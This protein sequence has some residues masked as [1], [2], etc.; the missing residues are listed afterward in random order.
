MVVCGGQSGTGTGLLSEY[1]GFPCQSSFL[2]F[3]HHHN[4]PGLRPIGGRSAEWTQMDPP[5]TI[6]IILWLTVYRTWFF[7]LAT[8]PLRLTTSNFIFQL[9]TCGYSPYVTS[10]LMMSFTIGAGPR[11]RSKVRLPRDSWPHFIA[12][13]SRLSQPGGPD[14]L[15]YRVAQLYP[16]ALGSLFV[17]S[18]NSHSHDERIRPHLHTRDDREL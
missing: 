15:I 11:Q 14:N 5:P 16:K 3:L 18:Y 9:N 4:H 12:S 1:Y 7:V 8:S 2:R 10:S 17:A 13:N 6:P